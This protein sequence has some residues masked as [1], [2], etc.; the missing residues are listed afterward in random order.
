M[1]VGGFKDM[2]NRISVKAVSL[3]VIFLA[4]SGFFSPFQYNILPADD[5]LELALLFSTLL[6]AS[7]LDRK[8]IPF[9][10]IAFSY[11]LVTAIWAA[12]FSNA[13]YLDYIQGYKAFFY[14]VAL[15]FVVRKRAFSISS[16]RSF[17]YFLFWMFSVKYAYSM[18]L[19]LDPRMGE[20][21]GIFTENNFELV[22]LVLLFYLVF[23]QLKYKSFFLVALLVLVFASGSRSAFVCAFV[24]FMFLIKERGGKYYMLLAVFLPF[25]VSA[26]AY[27]FVT[28]M[29]DG[30][31][32]ID[33][34]RFLLVFLSEV[35]D[36]EWWDFLLGT[37]PLTPLSERACSSLSYYD[38]LFSFS[39]DGTCYS[40][41]LHSYILR[42]VYDHGILGGVFLSLFYYCSL[43]RV[44]FSR[45]RAF[46]VI[47]V[48][49]VSS[50]SVSSFN[51]V[52][53][54]IAMFVY[55]SSYNDLNSS[56]KEVV[57]AS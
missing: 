43:R 32:S 38:E 57:Y 56:R 25:I 1:L 16:I 20:R 31:Q 21:P 55:F 44:G 18:F 30:L 14:V 15:S 39:G 40:V 35:K 19:D 28:R 5:L 50:L 13:H 51:S 42:V 27:L 37:A 26:G 24:V 10:V 4:F 23:W 6:L 2:L 12:F 8:T 7:S 9:F 34:Y 22:L 45:L 17:Y 52:Y 33:R 53:S 48:F 49:L 3:V 54:A 36:W 29:G 46:C 11:V 47:C 41:I